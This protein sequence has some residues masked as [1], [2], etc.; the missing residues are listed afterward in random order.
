ML[1]AFGLVL[2]GC[3][4]GG[5]E[6]SEGSEQIDCEQEMVPSFAEV[7]AFDVC[8]NCHSSENEGLERNGAPPSLNFDVYEIA[9]DT[10]PRMVNQV[11]M[12]H[13]PPPS[14]GFSLTPE[15]KDEL[16]VWAECGTPE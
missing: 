8:T 11:S 3:G 1:G 12:G 14:S 16:F 9:A 15:E 10:A 13:M 7:R 6:G 2:P 5:N 4:G